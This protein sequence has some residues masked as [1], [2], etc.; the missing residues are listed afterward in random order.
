MTSLTLIAAM[1]KNRVI[2]RGNELPWHLPADLRHFKNVTSGKPVVMGRKTYQSIGRP[3][4]NRTN[5]VMTRQ[6]GFAADGILV[7]ETTDAAIALADGADEIMVIGGEQVYTLFLPL[8][9][10]MLLT[11]VEAEVTGGDA[12]F[13]AF[14]TQD[15]IE[16]HQAF[17]PADAH[18]TYAFTCVDLR[19]K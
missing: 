19:R 17:F 11:R 12:H 4:P 10:R 8:A 3:L 2:G 18:N 16:Q 13:P 14:S 15:W 9:H 5:I 1:D 6:P 7:A